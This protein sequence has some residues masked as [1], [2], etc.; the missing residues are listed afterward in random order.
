MEKRCDVYSQV[1]ALVMEVEEALDEDDGLRT[2]YLL[3]DVR[4]CLRRALAFLTDEVYQELA[5]LEAI[6]SC[7][8]AGEGPIP[9]EHRGE[10]QDRLQLLHVKLARSLKLPYLQDLEQIMG[11]PAR[12]KLRLREEERERETR[13]RQREIEERCWDHESEARALL[14]QKHYPK[15]IKSLRKAVRLDPSRAVFHNDLGVVFSLQN[16]NT[17]AVQEYRM[18]VSL[19][20]RYPEQRT[21]EW[22]TSYYNLGIALRKVAQQD[23]A[24]NQIDEFKNHLCEAREAFK[25]YTRLS[26]TGPKVQDA[27]RVI[28]QISAQIQNIEAGAEQG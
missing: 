1:A 14:K 26:A 16:K 13:L 6:A 7:L 9:P 24:R 15:A 23:L 3:Q 22:T 2:R 19:N 17:D 10:L 5:R 8:P 18:A 11:L 21:E 28:E 4:R 20:E 25:E 27:R 12:L